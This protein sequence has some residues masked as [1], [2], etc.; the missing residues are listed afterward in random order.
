MEYDFSAGILTVHITKAEELPA[1]DIGGLSDPYVKL[2]LLPE[3]KRKYETKVHRKTL[4]PIF[5]ESFKFE[6]SKHYCLSWSFDLKKAPKLSLNVHGV[7]WYKI[8]NW[9]KNP[10]CYRWKIVYFFSIPKYINGNTKRQCSLRYG[11]PKKY[12]Y[13]STGLE[14]LYNFQVHEAESLW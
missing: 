10:G 3:R 13:T 4:N 8:W 7:S 1:M 11:L 5:N 9:A 6:V 14:G 12:I 2:Y